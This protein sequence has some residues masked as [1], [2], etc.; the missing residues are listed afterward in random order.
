MGQV[1]V[2]SH[3][4]LMKMKKD[5]EKGVKKEKKT[6]EKEISELMAKQVYEDTVKALIHGMVH[7]HLY[8]IKTDY[9]LLKML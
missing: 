8:I 9:I 1:Y 7:T 4:K 3:E 5:F 2:G 6:I